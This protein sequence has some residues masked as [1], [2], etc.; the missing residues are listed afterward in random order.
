M[1]CYHPM[2]GWRAKKE[3]ANGIRPIVFKVEQGIPET[4]MDIPCGKCVGCRL[5]KSRQWAIRCVHESQL[6]DENCFLTLTYNDDYLPLGGTLVPDDFQKFMKRLRKRYT[7]KSIRYFA[8]G[9][10]GDQ[11][12]RPHYHSILFGH[13]FQDK[14]VNKKLPSGFYE[15]VSEEL[16]SLW[17][18]GFCSIGTLTFE[19]AAYVARYVMKKKSGAVA[20]DHY[21]GR[22]PE[23]VRMSRRPGIASEWFARYK[24]EVINNDFVVIN[25]KKVGIPKFYDDQI[26][27]MDELLFQDLKDVRE[28]KSR[29]FSD[30]KTLV[31]LRDRETIQL[32]RSELLV[33]RF[34]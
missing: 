27:E 12:E 6:H 14:K 28:Y 15:Y 24:D 29:R 2:R 34:E 16:E 26:K 21:Q 13:D 4:V 18:F 5:E 30:D 31:R 11:K 32:K 7:G 9:E 10:Y 20:D 22:V 19:S 17:P 33:R 23:F 8:C 3:N 1:P 25:N